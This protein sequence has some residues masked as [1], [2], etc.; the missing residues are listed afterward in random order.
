MEDGVIK[1]ICPSNDETQESLN[2]KKSIL[3]MLQVQYSGT[4][5][6]FRPSTM[7]NPLIWTLKVSQTQ[8]TITLK[9]ISME[10]AS[11]TTNSLV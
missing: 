3:S 11:Q 4:A 8:E 9:K 2:L 10:N 1:N 5:Y 7:D 6:F